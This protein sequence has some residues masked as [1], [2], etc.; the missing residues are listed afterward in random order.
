[1]CDVLD[2]L[3]ALRIRYFITGSEAAAVYGVLRQ[4]FDTDVVVDLPAL[5]FDILERT[6]RA[7]YVVNE[8]I[9]FGDFAMASVISIETAEKVDLIMRQPGPWATQAMNRRQEAD[10]PRFGPVW[11]AA[12]E[13]LVLAK[14][15]W[16]EG[17][18]ELQMRDCAALIRINGEQ[19]DWPYTERWANALGVTALLEQ[20]RH[21]P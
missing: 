21:A 16:S 6:F 14:L 1:M 13:D 4:S 9:G 19:L 11:V 7:R 15:M 8:P 18:S 17:T 12:V 5:R 10:H 3:D 2:A 20:V